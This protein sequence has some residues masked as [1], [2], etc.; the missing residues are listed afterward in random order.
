MLEAHKWLEA[1]GHGDKELHPFI[2]HERKHERLGQPPRIWHADIRYR[3]W[4][5][6]RLPWSE[7]FGKASG[8]VYSLDG[9]VPQRSCNE[10]EVAKLLREVRPEAYWISGFA[11]SQIPDLWRPWVL[12]PAE[13]PSWLKEFDR[14]LRPRVSAPRG[15]MP[16]VVAWDP[17]RELESVLFLECKGP[18]EKNKEAQEGWVAAAIDEGVP[19]SNFAA[20]IRVFL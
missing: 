18:K 4:D 19:A 2:A 1:L 20:A 7:D 12:G 5:G 11:P 8:Q 3:Q 15:G 16:D 14:R 6:P 17:H 9:G 10:V 13:A